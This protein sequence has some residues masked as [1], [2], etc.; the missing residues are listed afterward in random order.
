MG[1]AKH[2][3]RK[4]RESLSKRLGK[5]ARLIKA[6]DSHRCVYCSATEEEAGCPLQLDHLI[7]R[8]AGGDDTPENLVVACKRCNSARQAMTLQQWAR[9][10][11]TKLGLLFTARK[12]TNQAKR[13][14]D[15]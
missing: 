9:Y 11:K 2:D 10:A 13:K 4:N 7:C 6:R 14:L 3:K 5:T 15:N 12:V 1:R 8:S